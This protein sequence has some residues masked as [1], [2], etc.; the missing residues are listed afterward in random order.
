MATTREQKSDIING[1]MEMLGKAQ[2]MVI[3]EYRGMQMKNFNATRAAMRAAKGG[4]TVTK[5]TLLKIALKETGFA[6]P[7]DLLKGPTAVAV[8]GKKE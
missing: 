4:Y 7:E 3:T 5:N 2:G 8:A 6:V 1:Y